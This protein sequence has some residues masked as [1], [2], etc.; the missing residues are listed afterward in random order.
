MRLQRLHLA[1]KG[2]LVQ[3]CGDSFPA[4][5]ALPHLH[6]LMSY[7]A[8]ES[9][10][11]GALFQAK[12]RGCKGQGK[13]MYMATGPP[14]LHP[15]QHGFAGGSL[16]AALRDGA[17]KFAEG[18]SYRKPRGA[19]GGEKATEDSHHQSENYTFSQQSGSDLEGEGKI[20]ESLKIDGAGS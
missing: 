3:V 19:D 7:S 5:G 8:H 1:A 6:S 17:L 2:T 11:K 16:S 13:V 10:K 14:E 4:E 20:G 12:R 9:A 15:T 18:G